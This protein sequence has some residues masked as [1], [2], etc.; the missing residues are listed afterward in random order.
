M[1]SVEL[2]PGTTELCDVYRWRLTAA[3]TQSASHGE[4]ETQSPQRPVCPRRIRAGA[5]CY[6]WVCAGAGQRSAAGESANRY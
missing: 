3:V 2:A 1:G 6:R 5:E 4:H